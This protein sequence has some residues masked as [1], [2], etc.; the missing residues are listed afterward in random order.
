MPGSSPRPVSEPSEVCESLRLAD[1]GT[2]RHKETEHR[3]CSPSTF[4][5]WGSCRGKRARH[6]WNLVC[7]H[8]GYVPPPI[9]RSAAIFGNSAVP[10]IAVPSPGIPLFV[11]PSPEWQIVDLATSLYGKALV[12]LYDNFGPDSIGTSPTTRLWRRLI[13]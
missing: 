11:H 9:R 13:N 2:N 3:Q 5:V 10:L 8:T 1:M 12:P 7:Q 4:R 6:C